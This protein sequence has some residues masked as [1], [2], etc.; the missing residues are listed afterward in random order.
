MI[1]P[2]Y[3]HSRT[4][5]IPPHTHTRKGGGHATIQKK[6]YTKTGLPKPIQYD[7][8]KHV[9]ELKIIIII[10]KGEDPGHAKDCP[11]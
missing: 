5:T 4:R 8:S 1:Y 2:F 9:Q 10:K 6:H 7:Y 3:I 11:N